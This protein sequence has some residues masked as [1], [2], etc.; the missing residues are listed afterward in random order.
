MSRLAKMFG[1]R[2][3]RH[4]RLNCLGA[5]MRR[6]P[7]RDALGRLN[8]DREVG[9]VMLIRAAD[10]ERQAQLIA[11]R[12]RHCQANQAATMGCHVIDVF[13]AHLGS[14]HDEIALVLAVFVIDHDDH[15]A[16]RYVGNDVFNIAE[17]RVFRA[18]VNC[19]VVRHS[20]GPSENR[21][22]CRRHPDPAS[23]PDNGPGGRLRR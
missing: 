18:G 4:R 16:V 10:H 14:R 22:R 11:A 2:I 23:V 6:N 9:G 20:H 5:I 17:R 1:F 8:R 15:L 7:G 12:S 3:G 21:M 19:R 13:G